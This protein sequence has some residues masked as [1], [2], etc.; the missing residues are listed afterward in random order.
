MIKKV[1]LLTT[2]VLNIWAISINEVPKNITLE[3]DNGGLAKDANLWNSLSIK[4][5]VDINPSEVRK[6]LN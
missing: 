5:K 6:R 4:N 3:N 1:I 2:L